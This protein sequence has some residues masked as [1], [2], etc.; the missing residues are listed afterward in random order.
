MYGKFLLSI[1][2]LLLFT[3]VSGQAPITGTV[4]AG[5]TKETLPG[6]TIVLKGTTTGTVTD[7]DGNYS[8]K[9]PPGST[10]VFSY[11]GYITQEIT[12]GD[13]PRIDV[14]M[15]VTKTILN[16]VVVIGYGTVRKSDLSG[17]VS[18]VKSEDITRITA[19][20][21]VQSLQG[22]VAGVQITN[23]GG[24]GSTPDVK[25]RGVGTFNNYHPIYVVDGVILD[26]I[27]YLNSQDILSMEVL[28]DASAT[29]IYGA[30]GANG[31]IMVTTKLGTGTE[32]VQYNFTAEAGQ[33]RL[34]KKI[35]LLTGPEF[36]TVANMIQPG[37]YNNVDL[38]PNTDWQDEIFRSSAAMYN[39]QFSATGAG[40][41][42]DYY[43]SGGY[44]KQDGI[45][46]KSSYERITLQLNN[47]Y[48]FSKYVKIGNFLTITPFRAQFSPDVVI[49]A[50]RADPTI[51]P[52]YANGDF[53]AVPGVGNPLAAIEYSNNYNKGIRGV[54][55]IFAEIDFLK[56][57]TF[58]TS[59]G[60]DAG[61]S[62]ATNFTPAFTIYNP[63]S[64]IS[65][66]QNLT[67]DLFRGTS[68]LFTWLWENT[69]N[70]NKDIG[71][72]TINAVVGYTMQQTRSESLGITGENILRDD[73]NFWYI[74][75]TNIT[76]NTLSGIFT[77]IDPG[78]YYSMISYLFRINYVF[79]KRY[80][81]TVT[82][83]SDGSSKFAKNHQFANFPSFALGWNIGQERFLK[84]VKFISRLKLRASW[85]RIGN[86]KIN[87]N[88]RYAQ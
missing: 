37:S 30:R 68:T 50:Y 27:S 10:L 77:G 78:N 45:I 29:A 71:H 24:P 55:N 3:R 57:F 1:F 63:D 36:A 48:K 81:A 76:T 35:N 72:H 88:E 31:V 53:A 14:V 51:A 54:G 23:S 84:D 8:I 26:D 41:M 38:V 22:N 17:A 86:D 52:H 75:S 62:D 65:Q 15:A 70:Y 40:K 13:Q 39:V 49:M 7:L 28:K 60:I 67:S 61:Y 80:I 64:T 87:Y 2:L 32:K 21:P 79:N 69:L 6:A 73:P 47:T 33:Q 9:A 44:F 25:I 85:G 74:N 59:Y 42:N 46:P 58:K 66:Q 16:E 43:I 5:D 56:D 34:A 20:N 12:V 11:V 83:R 4:T 82:F 19:A 18:S